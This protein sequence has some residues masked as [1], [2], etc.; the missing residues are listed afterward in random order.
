MI[1]KSSLDSARTW[2]IDNTSPSARGFYSCDDLD[3]TAS[4]YRDG[5]GW[6]IAGGSGIIAR[7]HS[8]AQAAALHAESQYDY[9][10]YTSCSDDF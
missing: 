1:I 2:T 10:C 8:T 6:G 4:L 7:R 3:I 9:N 5:T